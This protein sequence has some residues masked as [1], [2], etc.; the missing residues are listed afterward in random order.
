[1]RKMSGFG[2]RQRGM[3]MLGIIFTIGLIAFFMTL[4]LKLGPLYLNF[5]TIRS[6]MTGVAEQSETLQGGARGIADTIGKRMDVNSVAN[7]TTKDFDIKKLEQ[8]TY[9]VTVNYEQRVHL[10]F[11]VDAVAMFTYQVDVKTQ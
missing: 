10:F 2:S 9:Q 7:I 5:W 1:M 6:I 3:G 4:L 8:N 11:N